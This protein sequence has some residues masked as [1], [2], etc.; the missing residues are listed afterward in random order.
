M[1]CLSG[2]IRGVE[3]AKTVRSPKIENKESTKNQQ[4]VIKVIKKSSTNHQRV[5]KK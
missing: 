3:T 4:L 2:V 5:I 1:V